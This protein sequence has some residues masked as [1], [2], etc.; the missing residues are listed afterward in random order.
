MGAGGV[1]GVGLGSLLFEL[2]LLRLSAQKRAKTIDKNFIRLGFE[3]KH[4]NLKMFGKK[5]GLFLNLFSLVLLK[6]HG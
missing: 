1:T 6:Y 4:V 3:V 5:K 2:Q